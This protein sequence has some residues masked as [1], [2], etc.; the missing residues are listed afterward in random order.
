MTEAKSGRPDGEEPVRAAAAFDVAPLAAALICFLTGASALLAAVT[1]EGAHLPGEAL[2]DRVLHELPELALSISGVALMALAF[3]LSR[4]LDAALVIAVVMLGHGALYSAFRTQDWPAAAVA[5]GAAGLLI[6]ARHAFYRRAAVFRFVPDARWS[7][8]LLAA[9][10]A[11]AVSAVLW[12]GERP[13]FADA[14]WWALIADPHLGRAGRA[15]TAA[16]IAG[17]AF[18]AW[19]ALLRPARPKFAAPGA[20]E[21]ERARA[22]MAR[23]EHPRPDQNL[24]LL[25]DKAF[26][27]LPSDT[28]FVMYARAGGSLIAMG[29]PVGARGEWRAAL[30]AFRAEADRQALRAVIYAAPP[31]LLPELI[32]L[33][34]RV[35]KVGE[36]AIVDLARFSLA[37][38]AMQNLRTARRKLAEREGATFEVDF[39]PHDA[40]RF[41][42]IAK[43]SD[44]WLARQKGGEK[45]F[46]LGR[47][48]PAYLADQPIAVVRKAGQPIAFANLMTTPDTSSVA[49]D[50][51]RHDPEL[52]PQGTMDFLFVELFAWAQAEGYRRFDLGMAPLSGLAEERYAPLFARF[53]RFV[54]ERGEAFY[55]FEGLRKFKDKFGPVWE[56]RYIAAP[57][58]WSLPLVL[59]EVALLTASSKPNP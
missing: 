12:A 16:G 47:F 52:S 35:E 56:P 45:S 58:A 43:V 39:P 22:V 9:F 14:P 6:A 41:A 11:A 32:E 48:A 44:A 36:S 23:A 38:K 28:A 1:P 3:G 57:G 13:G 59:A 18:L 20:D 21:L 27:F 8:A 19:A 37:G 4:R 30:A 40:A 55:G 31:D 54:F 26:L 24:A 46:S 5:A 53:G 50:L 29:A 34:F 2:A 10:A 17:A 51:M 7:L 25:R 33:G 42:A 49:I 15:L